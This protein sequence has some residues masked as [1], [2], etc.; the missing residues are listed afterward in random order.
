MQYD[1]D[2]QKNYEAFAKF[3]KRDADAI[4]QWDAWIGGLAEVLGPLLMT[5][6]PRLGSL[7]ARAISR[8]S[9]GS[10]GGSAASTCA[11]SPT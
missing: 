9:S 2:A 5:T 8:S 11:G 4:E 3:S 6:P 10:R 7:Q 1:D